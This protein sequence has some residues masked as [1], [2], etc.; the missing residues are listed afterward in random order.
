MAREHY[1]DDED[2]APQGGRSLGVGTFLA[3]LALGAGLALLLA[4]QTGPELRRKIRRTARKA[5]SAAGELAEDMKLKAQDLAQDVKHRAEDILDEAKSEFEDRLENAR[6]VIARK[7]R[8]VTRAVDAGRSA[9]RDARES[10][11]RRIADARSEE[12]SS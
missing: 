5:Q 12:R 2:E 11:E 1:D 7:R 3:G 9:A 6:G 10:F 8:E 4:P